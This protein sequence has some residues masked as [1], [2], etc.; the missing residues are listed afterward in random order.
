MIYSS[1]ATS[2]TLKQHDLFKHATKPKLYKW[3]KTMIYQVK[4]PGRNKINNHTEMHS[5]WVVYDYTEIQ[6]YI[7]SI[8]I[9]YVLK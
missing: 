6:N 4:Y 5:T 8:N 9:C 7:A 1:Y 3:K 2:N